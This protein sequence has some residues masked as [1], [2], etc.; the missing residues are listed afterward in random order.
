MT[1]APAQASPAPSGVAGPV[2]RWPFYA[3][4]GTVLLIECAFTL[5]KEVALHSSK[6]SVLYSTADYGSGLV[7]RG[8]SGEFISLLEHVPFVAHGDFVSTAT[9]ANYLFAAAYLA[10]AAAVIWALLAGKPVSGRATVLACVVLLLPGWA[11]QLAATRGMVTVGWAVL[12]FYCVALF[13]SRSDRQAVVASSLYGAAM[14]VLSLAHEAAVFLYGMGA[15]LAVAVFLRE[16]SGWFRLACAAL[17]LAPGLAATAVVALFGKTGNDVVARQCAKLPDEVISIPLMGDVEY[18]K[19]AYTLVFRFF[20]MTPRESQEDW[21][22]AGPVALVLDMVVGL[23]VLLLVMKYISHVSG[24]GSRSFVEILVRDRVNV[25]L[26]LAGIVL[27]VPLFLVA[28]DWIRFWGQMTVDIALVRILC[29]RDSMADQ[30]A[31]T[32]K[33]RVLAA[34][35]LASLFLLAL[36]PVSLMPLSALKDPKGAVAEL[37][38]SVLK[39][40]PRE[41]LGA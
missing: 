14:A 12:A 23:L 7:R 28:V 8:L 38:D 33:S 30:P 40:A 10:G 3:V 17:S 20:S 24:V 35:L 5:Y 2:S 21:L 26:L 37:Y 36:L 18:R 1:H 13:K 16:K 4:C 34:P 29:C 41:C 25:L 19:Y 39:K 31:L 11:E 27:W 6:Y 32:R 9:F 15:L 22:K